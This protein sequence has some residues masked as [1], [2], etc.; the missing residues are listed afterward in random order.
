MAGQYRFKDSNGNIVA[1]ISASVEGAIAFSGSVVDFTQANNVILGNVQLAGTA[2]N[3]LLLD[4]FDSQAFAFTSSIHPFTA[5]I[6]GTNTFTRI[7]KSKKG[8]N[9]S[10]KA[11]VRNI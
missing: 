5:S 1:Q 3:A 2:S 9:K 4:G 6:A 7:F 11:R 8:F 10:R